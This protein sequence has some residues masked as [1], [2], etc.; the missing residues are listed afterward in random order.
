MNERRARWFIPTLATGLYFSQGFPYG[1][2]N[3]ALPLYLSVEGVSATKVGLVTTIGLAWTF[4]VFWAPAVDLY[5]SY[6]RWIMGSLAILAASIAALG[7][8]PAASTAFWAIAAVLAI[9]SAT[10]DIAIDALTIR[11]TP[12][13]LLGPVN[14][15]RVAAFR[16]AIIAAGGGLALI[17]DWIGWRLTFFV[18]GALCIALIFFMFLIPEREGIVERR[19]NPF[20]ALLRWLVRPQAVA[21]LVII[22]LYRLGDSALTP[23]VPK[24]W[25]VRGYTAGEIGA[26]IST[27]GM[28]STI[29][30]AVAGG[31]FV[32]RAGIYRGLLWLGILQMLSNVGYAAAAQFDAGRTGMYSAALVEAFCNGLG[33]AAFLSFL[34]Y[35]CDKENA[36]TEY[37]MLSAM[38]GLSRTLAGMISGFGA[39]RLGWADYFWATVLLG[40]PGLL[41]LPIIRKALAGATGA[42]PAA[43]LD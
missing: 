35:I 7:V 2:A 15:A 41:L 20:R 23:M 10:Q 19:E 25:A 34:M 4:K 40:V 32:A 26:V 5:G 16:V 27:L 24:F 17:S 43:A 29:A 39:D 18:A 1:I 14:S 37:A 22:F 13:D 12:R 21:F 3:Y 31:L 9:A 42:A 38:F 28:I 6:R 30:G 33:T 36:A 8:V 11:I